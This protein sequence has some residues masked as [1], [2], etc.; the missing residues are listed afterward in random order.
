MKTVPLKVDTY[1][2]TCLVPKYV[3]KSSDTMHFEPCFFLMA[4]YSETHTKLCFYVKRTSPS[5]AKTDIYYLKL[6]QS[7][8][9][10]NE[11]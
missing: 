4:D 6:K 7:M 3:Y 9:K 2:F 10:A 1:S 11:S 5:K 8:R